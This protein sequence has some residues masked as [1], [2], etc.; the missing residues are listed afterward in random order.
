MKTSCLT[1]LFATVALIVSAGVDAAS[2]S[3]L[4]SSSSVAQNGTF[5]IDLALDAADAPGSHPG[6]FLGQ[7]TID[8][9]PA[10]LAYQGFVYSAPA[11]QYTFGPTTGTSGSRQTVALDFKDAT[12]TSTIGVF[13][14][15]AIGSPGATTVGIAD[16]PFN[17]FLNKW[18]T[19]QPFNPALN[20]TSIDISAVPLPATAWLFATGFAL[21]G[22]RQ[23]F[24][25]KTSTARP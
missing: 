21:I 8:F 5:T 9:D 19:D 1:A 3:L 20:G 6:L 10:K 15:K 18:P 16:D 2:I 22:I 14:F 24:D 25:R 11:S 17:P 12:D 4:P 23:R 13:T 7:V